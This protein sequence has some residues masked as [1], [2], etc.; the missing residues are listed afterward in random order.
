MVYKKKINYIGNALK[1]NHMK[2]NRNLKSNTS[3]QI[4]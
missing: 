4:K 2:T 3:I 1:N